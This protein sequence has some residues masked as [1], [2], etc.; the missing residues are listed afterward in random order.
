MS[1]SKIRRHA[2]R[3]RKADSVEDKLDAVAK[4]FK[5]LADTLDE[6]VN[7]LEKEK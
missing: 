5:A 2:R 3:I 4:A 7:I 6:I 1:T